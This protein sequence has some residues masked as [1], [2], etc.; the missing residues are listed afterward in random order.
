MTPAFISALTPP[1][2]P[3]LVEAALRALL[4]AFAVWAGLRLFGI[5]NVLAQKAAWGLVLVAALNMPLA[6][7]LGMRWQLLPAWAA[8][9]L[10]QNPWAQATSSRPAAPATRSIAPVAVSLPETTQI[11]HPASAGGDRFPAPRISMSESESP[12]EAPVPAPHAPPYP[13]TSSED[14]APQSSQTAFPPTAVAWLLY[15][16]VCALLVFRLL[17]GLGLSLRLWFG[18]RPVPIRSEDPWISRLAANVPLRASTRIASPV[19]IGSGIVLPID[20]TT[21]DAEKL[22]IVLAHERSHIRQGDFY[23]QLLAGLYASLFWFSPLGWWLKRKLSEL[24]ETI[25]DRA[26]LEEAASRSSYAQILIEFAALPRPTPIGVAM[27]ST[28]TLSHRIERLLNDSSFRQ[29]FAGT[30]RRVLLAVLLVPAALFAA[31]ALI[32]VEAAAAPG[33]QAAPQAPVTGQSNPDAAQDAAPAQ[34]PTAPQAPSAAPNPAPAVAPLPAPEP[35][36]APEPPGPPKPLDGEK[37]IIIRK[38]I[39]KDREI[40]REK[41]LQL[42]T[43][44]NERFVS[45]G[46]GSSHG[47]G[48][49]YSYSYSSNGE[50]YALVSG[51]DADVNFSGDWNHGHSDEIKKAAKMAHGK[52]L[53]FLRDGKS[54]MVEDPAMLAQ[55]ETL[56]S[57]MESLGKQ[58]EA[59]GRDQEKLGEKQEALGRQQEEAAVPTPDISKEMA[60]LDA[61]AAKLAAK[62]GKTVSQEE[63]G[64]LQDQLGEIQGKL[65]ELQGEMGS[66]QGEIGAR[67]GEL[68]A[69]QGKLGAQQ[70]KLGAE[71]G[72]LAQE[73]DRKVKSIIDE[74]LK[75]GKARPVN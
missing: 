12:S 70:G 59:L 60:K 57:Q 69:Q 56:N 2:V 72:R 41:R 75:N 67:Q 16:A 38:E 24:G 22:R 27:A 73:E 21:W 6:M 30:R 44:R 28:S 37:R 14:T 32:R 23:L 39:Q 33:V 13:A 34:A 7:N 11:Q 61:A 64:D 26:G 47:E 65:G 58:Q 10:P 54:Y 29:A 48:R 4:V 43:E 50:T 9:R 71:Q 52:F 17:Y 68:G 66:R 5:R 63:L 8:I 25:S 35:D 3:A 1:F 74:S 49:G 51:P 45:G 40:Q 31:T 19:T 15:L 53:W 18:A 36:V 62:I 55:I 42:R 20:Y 46:G